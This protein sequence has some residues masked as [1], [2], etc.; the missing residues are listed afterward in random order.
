MIS[1]NLPF[2]SPLVL[3]PI[4][5]YTD[6]PFRL[7]CKEQGAGLVYTEL[8]SAEALCRNSKKTYKLTK[9]YHDE[10]PAA[11]QL[12]GSS[13]D[14]MAEAAEIVCKMLPKPALIDINSGCCARKICNNNSGAALMK[15]PDLVFNIISQ[16]KSVSDVPVTLKIRLGFTQN[17]KNYALIIEKAALAGASAVTIHGRTSDQQYSGEADWIE[18][19]KAAELSPI[20]VIGN[21][22]IT[23]YK[24][25]IEKLET[26][27]CSGIMIAR[28]A[29]G[30]PWIFSNHEPSDNERFETAARHA[31]MMFDYYGDHGI[32]M[33]RKHMVKYFHHKKNSS[34]LRHKLVTAKT[35]DELMEILNP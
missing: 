1:E 31:R 14:R 27:S 2:T 20:P 26:T 11:V 17:T 8:I 9:I 23:S 6:Y 10:T 15:D 18:I 35:L 21:G 4:A 24:Q 34:Q 33:A 12:F 3:A 13:P 25:A 19:E 7:L 29:I 5:G 30:N 22:D 16:I 28:G 32:I